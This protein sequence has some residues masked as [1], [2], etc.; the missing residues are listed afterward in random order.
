MY[1]E[2]EFRK[3]PRRE[4][5][6]LKDPTGAGD[7]YAGAFLAEYMDLRRRGHGRWHAAEQSARFASVASSLAVEE[8]GFKGIRGREWIE[9]VLN[10]KRS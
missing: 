9:K 7:V 10:E 8:I 5:T 4:P 6:E 3:I 2:Q 1:S